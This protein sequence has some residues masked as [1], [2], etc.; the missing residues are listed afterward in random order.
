M[1]SLLTCLNNRV[2]KQALRS[3]GANVTEKHIT[4]VSLSALFL[5]KAATKA[6]TVLKVPQRSTSHTIRDANKDM[7][8]IMHHLLDKKVSEEDKDRAKSSP[9][10][11]DLNAVGLKKLTTTRWLQDLLIKGGSESDL[12]EDSQME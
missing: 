2:V 7:L 10:F 4:D 9:S 1:Y 6:D 3:S 8:K 12:D 11:T 5:M